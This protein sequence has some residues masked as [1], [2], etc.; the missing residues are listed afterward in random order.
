MTNNETETDEKLEEDSRPQAGEPDSRLAFRSGDSGRG[1]GPG[2]AVPEDGLQGG[3][4][5]RIGKSRE[6]HGNPHVNLLHGIYWR[7]FL[8]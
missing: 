4:G 1:E 7:H 3:D 2:A 6:K 8:R 5:R